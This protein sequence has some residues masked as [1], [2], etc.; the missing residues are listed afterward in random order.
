MLKVVC[1]RTAI[2]SFVLII[3]TAAAFGQDK[4]FEDRRTP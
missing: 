2:V 1:R 3:I 4:V